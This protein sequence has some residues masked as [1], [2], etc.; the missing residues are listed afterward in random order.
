MFVSLPG[1][2]PGPHAETSGWALLFVALFGLAA[3]V[4]LYLMLAWA[5]N[6]RGV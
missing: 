3:A 2:S 4:A 5:A 6:F 1:G